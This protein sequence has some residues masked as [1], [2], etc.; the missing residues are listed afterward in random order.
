MEPIYVNMM[1][2]RHLIYCFEMP[3][4]YIDKINICD[5]DVLE[6]SISNVTDR[7]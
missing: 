7:Y 1:S 6:V 2:H 3:Y 5:R 4:I